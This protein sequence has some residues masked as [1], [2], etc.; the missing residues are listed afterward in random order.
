[1]GSQMKHRLVAAILAAAA[2]SSSVLCLEPAAAA[3]RQETQAAKTS[4][5]AAEKSSVRPGAR[6]QFQRTSRRGA[7]QAGTPKRRRA[8]GEGMS[9]E[10]KRAGRDTDTGAA[11]APLVLQQLRVVMRA[12][13]NYDE[14]PKGGAGMSGARLR[15]LALI[16]SRPGLQVGAFAK[17]LGVHQ[18][19]ASN[20]L[21]HLAR[22]GLVEKR[23]D[24]DDHRAVSLFATPRAATVLRAAPALRTDV[25][26]QA[27]DRLPPPALSALHER[28]AELIRTLPAGTI[29]RA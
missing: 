3:Q 17:E 14:R 5:P 12:I 25:L 26:R 13:R 20:T 15:A 18:S 7:K 10:A 6:W 1:M 9:L 28:L 16:D 27:L 4:A 8:I 2:L 19:T 23:R 29:A 21:E 11:K 24:G 22:R